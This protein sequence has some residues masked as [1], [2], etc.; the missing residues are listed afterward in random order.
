METVHRTLAETTR[1]KDASE[2]SYYFDDLAKGVADGS[3]SRRQALKWLGAGAVA[4]AIGPLFPEQAEALTRRQRRLCRRKGGTPLERGNC[5]CG[6]NCLTATQPFTCQGN[7]NCTCFRTT[8][9]RGFCGA[10]VAPCS[11]IFCSASGD[12]PAGSR[13]VVDD[14]CDLPFCVRPCP[15]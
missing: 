15:T 1:G 8:E 4:L 7:P 14:C 10:D 13:C 3:I 5:H 11:T 2:G 12:C 9:N 6:F